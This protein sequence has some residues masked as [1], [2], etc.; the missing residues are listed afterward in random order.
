MAEQ[1]DF[2]KLRP[3]NKTIPFV[4]VRV[5]GALI[6][7]EMAGSNG[8]AIGGYFWVIAEPV[9]GV[10]LLTAIF[11][12]GFRSPPIGTNFP[13]FYA[14]GL[15]PFFMFMD[16]SNK[17]AQSINFSRQLL[18]YRRVTFLDAIL[19]RAILAA[20]TQLMVGFIVFTAILV[21]YETRTILNI[22]SILLSYSMAIAAALSI[23]AMNAVIMSFFPIWQRVWG[24]L[25]RPLILVSGVI[26]LPWTFPEPIR[27]YLWYNPLIHVTGEMRRAFYYSYDGSYVSPIYVFAV[28]IVIGSVSLLFLRRYHREILEL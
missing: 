11:S 5:I 6:L 7:R 22:P 25:T 12:L 23:G 9:L 10:M 3:V 8:R 26:F 19:A 20:L 16:I 28:S 4:T 21:M 18:G 15:L 1:P 17:T 24:I 13:I 2:S 27:G 14:T